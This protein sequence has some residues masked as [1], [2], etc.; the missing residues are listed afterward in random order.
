M[1][2]YALLL[3]RV[4]ELNFLFNHLQHNDDKDV[5]GSIMVQD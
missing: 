5:T 4:L 3:G 2:S 1:L